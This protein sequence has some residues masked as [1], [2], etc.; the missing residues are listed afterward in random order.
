MCQF[1]SCTFNA[2]IIMVNAC[3]SSIAAILI[4]SMRNQSSRIIGKLSSG[5]QFKDDFLNYLVIYF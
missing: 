3:D 5:H 1:L 4:Y 2:N